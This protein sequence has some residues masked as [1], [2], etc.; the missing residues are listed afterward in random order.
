[1]IVA[2]EGDRYKI[3]VDA[4]VEEYSVRNGMLLVSRSPLMTKELASGAVSTF[5]SPE[6]KYLSVDLKTRT[7]KEEK[8]PIE[9]LLC[10]RKKNL[11]S[12]QAR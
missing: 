5:V 1:M 12:I 3:I 8:T 6:C 7:I 2:R 4:K 11:Q 9:G 10:K